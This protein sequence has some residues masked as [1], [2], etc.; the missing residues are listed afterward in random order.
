MKGMMDDGE[1]ERKRKRNNTHPIILS[2]LTFDAKFIHCF[3][4]H[5]LSFTPDTVAIYGN[6]KNIG[7]HQ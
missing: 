7:L 6:R 5:A 3:Q 4:Y 1:E 2:S